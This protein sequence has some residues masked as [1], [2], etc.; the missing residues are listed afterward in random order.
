MFFFLLLLI[1][2]PA[3]LFPLPYIA[4]SYGLLIYY[5]SK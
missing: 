1:L 4:L 3:D 5:L 2:L